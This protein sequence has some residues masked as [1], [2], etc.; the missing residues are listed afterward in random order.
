MYLNL[1]LQIL[2]LNRKQ[3]TPEPLKTSKIPTNP[4]EIH[5]PQPRLSLRILHPIPNTLQNARERGYADAGAD[6]DCDF[7]L[8]DV[9]GGGAE[10]AVDVDAGE[11]PAERGVVSEVAGFVFF[12]VGGR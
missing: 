2:R 3:K 4:K 6:E 7:E 1:I 5:L 10:G 11:D 8:E 12:L 9:F